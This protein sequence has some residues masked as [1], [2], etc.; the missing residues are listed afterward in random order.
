MPAVA[1]GTGAR[2]SGPRP[3]TTFPQSLLAPGWGWV[4]RG[5]GKCLVAAYWRLV[6]CSMPA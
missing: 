1:A 6:Y 3:G 4:G 2:V 5:F